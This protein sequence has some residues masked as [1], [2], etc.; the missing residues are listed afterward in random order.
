LEVDTCHSIQR[1]FFENN[2]PRE[3]VST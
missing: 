1:R 2:R 3:D